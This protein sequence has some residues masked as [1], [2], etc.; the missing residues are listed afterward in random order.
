[1]KQFTQ[2]MASVVTSD[3]SGTIQGQA[4]PYGVEIQ[5]GYYRQVIERGAFSRQVKDPARVKLLWQ[6]DSSRPI[7]RATALADTADGLQVSGT[8]LEQVPD[9]ALALTM[10]REGVIDEMSIG[11]AWDKFTESSDK[12]GP[13]ITHHKARLQEIS[14][15]T[16]GAAEREARVTSVHHRGTHSPQFWRQAF[17]LR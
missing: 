4:V 2:L 14:L 12:D 7:G 13:L 1:M 10:L 15:V 5:D 3:E 17:S 16:A 11:F 9:G 8:I 6:H